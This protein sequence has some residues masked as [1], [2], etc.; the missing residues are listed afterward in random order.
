MLEW[1]RRPGSLVSVRAM[2]QKVISPGRSVATPASRVSSSQCG[3]RI[4]ET[5]DEVLLLDIGI[6][7]GELEG[8]ELIAM[9]ADAAR[10]EEARGNRK[11]AGPMQLGIVWASTRAF[12]AGSSGHGPRT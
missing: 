7:Q 9:D 8:G 1:M 3:G 10:Q 6:A 12:G 5:R 4:E 2:T 11:H